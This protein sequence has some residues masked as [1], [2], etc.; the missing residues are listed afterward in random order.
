MN[1]KQA[2]TLDAVFADPVRA[3]IAWDD[4]ESLLLAAGAMVVE[5]RGSRVRFRKG[6][7][8]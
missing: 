1:S 2:R 4:V 3:N 8:V 7:M 5:S 6:D